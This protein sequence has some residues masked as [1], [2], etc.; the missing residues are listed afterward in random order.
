M[1]LSELVVKKTSQSE[2]KQHRRITKELNALNAGRVIEMTIDS[3]AAETVTSEEAIP[4]F[5]TMSPSGPERDTK[6]VLP[7]GGAVDNQGEKHVD[8]TTQEGAKCKIR[9]QVTQVRKSLMS[10]SKICD[11]GHRVVFNKVGGY[12]E[13]EE[14][15]QRTS[16]QRKG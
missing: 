13:H 2:Q 4:E 16:F 11:A 12:I 6:Y 8:V 1:P 10:V 14:T 3:G 7:D 9:M 15:G 5:P